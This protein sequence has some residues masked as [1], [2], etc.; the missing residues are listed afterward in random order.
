[1]KIKFKELSVITEKPV[2]AINITSIVEKYVKECGI[3]EGFIYIMTKHT[4]TGLWVNE[5]LPCVEEDILNHLEK[6]APENDDYV[7]NHFL[8]EDGTLGYNA[9]SHIKSV[10]MGYFLYFPIHEGRL[11][12]GA[13]QTLYL[14]E[15][16]GPKPREYTIQV[17]GD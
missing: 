4:T 13:R 6:I 8:I 5:G 3:A 7:H 15:L 16:D 11:I 9:N 10:L 1:V 2:Q 17:I 12:K 14:A